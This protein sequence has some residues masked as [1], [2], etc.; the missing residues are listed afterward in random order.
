MGFIDKESIPTTTDC[1]LHRGETYQGDAN[2]DKN[3]Y[4]CV[5]DTFCRNP[6]PDVH[7]KPYCNSTQNYENVYCEITMC[8]NRFGP[9]VG[10]RGVIADLG[11]TGYNDKW[12]EQPDYRY[13][14]VGVNSCARKLT[15]AN[16]GF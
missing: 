13:N 10:S 3:G 12:H 6:T 5:D 16:S 4:P 14:Q 11:A 9:F 1:F 8:H 2:T 15:L 7:L